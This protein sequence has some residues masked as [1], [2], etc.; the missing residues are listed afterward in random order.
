VEIVEINDQFGPTVTEEGI[1]ALVVSEE[2]RAGGEAVNKERARKGWGGLEV[3]VVGVVEDENWGGM[4]MSST[5][6]RRRRGEA[7]RT[8]EGEGEDLRR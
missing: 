1:S 7:G 3:F 2:T 4:K 8:V 5:E 6:I